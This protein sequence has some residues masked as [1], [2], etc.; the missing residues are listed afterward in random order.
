[1]QTFGFQGHDH[2]LKS[3]VDH[4]LNNEL[5][6]GAKYFWDIVITYNVWASWTLS[7][8]YEPCKYESF[9]TFLNE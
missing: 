4:M 6:L 7:I 9:T 5:F 8:I 3:A 1:M 2:S